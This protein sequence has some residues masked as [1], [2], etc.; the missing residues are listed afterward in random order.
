MIL[1]VNGD[2]VEIPEAI[3]TIT[4]LLQHFKLYDKV[5]IV[6]KNGEILEK[7][8]HS[9]SLISDKDSIELVHFVGGG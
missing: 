1:T 8:K 9:E 7:A 4:E 5:I 2:Q 3:E 6:E